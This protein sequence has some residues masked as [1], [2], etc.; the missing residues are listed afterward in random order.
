MVFKMLR[1]AGIP[2]SFYLWDYDAAVCHS[3]LGFYE[4]WPQVS[5]C[6]GDGYEG[7]G[8]IPNPSL[9]LIDPVSIKGDK[10]RTRILNTLHHFRTKETPFICWTA[11]VE[12]EDKDFEALSGAVETDFSTHRVTWTP[13]PK[14]TTKGCQ[15]TVPK[16]EPWGSLAGNIL[17]ELRQLMNWGD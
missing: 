13:K 7:V 17:N 5:V 6:R 14:T 15:I 2:F 1:K 10:E 4:N 16:R 12:G 3:L 9:A 8:M 11:I